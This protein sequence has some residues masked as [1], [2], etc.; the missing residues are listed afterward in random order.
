MCLLTSIT[1][2]MHLK[3]ELYVL[4]SG[5][6]SKKSILMAAILEFK[7][8]AILEFKMA[9]MQSKYKLYQCVC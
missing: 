2:N 8:A 3:S 5:Y 9:A 1:N 6:I 7:M 4:F